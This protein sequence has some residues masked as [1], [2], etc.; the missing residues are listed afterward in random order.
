MTIVGRIV[1]RIWGA[2]VSPLFAYDALMLHLEGGR[3]LNAVTRKQR[4]R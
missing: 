4:A 1:R 2:R 3:E